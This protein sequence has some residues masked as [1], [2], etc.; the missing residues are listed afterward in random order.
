MSPEF[1]VPLA[2]L[3]ALAALVHP[4]GPWGL[5]CPGYP[6]GLEGPYHPARHEVLWVPAVP[7]DPG[8]PSVLP[9]HRHLPY[10]PSVPAAPAVLWLLDSPGRPAG[11][12]VPVVPVVP[13]AHPD[14]PYRP[15]VPAILTGPAALRLLSGPVFLARPAAPV[16][17]DCLPTPV[18]PVA[19]ATQR[20]QQRLP[21]R[22][23]LAARQAL[24]D[25]GHPFP[26]HRQQ[27]RA[28]QESG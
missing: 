3:A 25:H 13:A 1:L 10:R 14:L 15:S 2:A 17:Q 24:P 28:T 5:N 20:R 27:R 12:E 7:R 8:L 11:H 23:A 26:Q 19:P 16:A 22:R 18:A 9:A 6:G 21:D 4:V